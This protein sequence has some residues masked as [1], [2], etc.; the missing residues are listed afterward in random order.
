MPFGD[1]S[2]PLLGALTVQFLCLWS[3]AGDLLGALQ[4]HCETTIPSDDER[5]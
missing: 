2:R 1:C 4:D 3:Q 5:V